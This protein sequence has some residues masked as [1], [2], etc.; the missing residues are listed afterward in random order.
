MSIFKKDD[1]VEVN[2]NKEG[3]FLRYYSEGMVEVRLW[4]GNRHIGDVVVSES[5]IRRTNE[6]EY[7]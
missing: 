6:R 2:C 4:D 5:E 1:R 3:K 7:L